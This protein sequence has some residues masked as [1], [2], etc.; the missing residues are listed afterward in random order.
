MISTRFDE[1]EILAAIN[2]LKDSGGSKY[3]VDLV[4][5]EFQKNIKLDNGDW[6]PGKIIRKRSFIDCIRTKSHGL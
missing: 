3:N 4:R 1:A 6:A 2:Q 5:S